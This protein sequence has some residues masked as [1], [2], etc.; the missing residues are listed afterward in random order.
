MVP[1]AAFTLAED[2][3]VVEV[4]RL[5]TVF[6][7]RDD[8][9][10]RREVFVGHSPRHP[11]QRKLLFGD[12]QQ[13]A[14]KKQRQ[15]ATRCG[16]FWCHVGQGSAF[17]Y[18][19]INPKEAAPTQ[20]VTCHVG[21]VEAGVAPMPEKKRRHTLPKTLERATRCAHRQVVRTGCPFAPAGIQI[22]RSAPCLLVALG[23]TSHQHSA[24]V[25]IGTPAEWSRST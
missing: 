8:G 25:C 14:V 12:G 15:H 23:R 20:R 19:V 11:R 3:V 21:A 17:Y 2:A 5:E 10:Q 4:S 22:A 7:E 13:I 24:V 1:C 9:H 6:D 16:R 18:P